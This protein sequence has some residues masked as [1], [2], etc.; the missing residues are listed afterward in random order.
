MDFLSVAGF[1]G[2]GLVVGYGLGLKNIG[3]AQYT[4]AV[5]WVKSIYAKMPWVK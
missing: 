4:A 1:I 5:N 2:S 3:V